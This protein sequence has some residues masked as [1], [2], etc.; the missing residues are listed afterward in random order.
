MRTKYKF[1][2]KKED[3]KQEFLL[4]EENLSP[5]IT[6]KNRIFVNTKKS[7]KKISLD[8]TLRND[9]KKE[10]E[11]H[12]K[13]K[14]VLHRANTK[15]G[16]EFKNSSIDEISNKNKYYNH[17]NK[18]NRN[19]TF[20]NSNN[21]TESTRKNLLMKMLSNERKSQNSDYNKLKDEQLINKSIYKNYRSNRLNK[22]K[23]L[24]SDVERT[25][26]LRSHS[27]RNF[28]KNANLNIDKSNIYKKIENS[29][30]NN[31][32]I[33]NNNFNNNNLQAR[34]FKR[35]YLEEYKNKYEK[36]EKEKEKK[37]E[38]E[39]EKEKEKNR[40]K[41]E[42]KKKQKEKESE[43]EKGDK[44]EKDKQKEK[45]KKREVSKI[46]FNIMSKENEK[47]LNVNGKEPKKD[48]YKR[49]Y[50]YFENHRRNNK[51]KELRNLDL[52]INNFINNT[53][54]IT[55]KSRGIE[56]NRI[57]N[58]IKTKIE[59]REKKEYKNEKENKC[60]NDNKENLDN[61]EDKEKDKE[62]NN[63]K[64][65]KESKDNM[66]NKENKENN[67]FNFLIHEAHQNQRIS[68]IFNK[69]Y[70]SCPNITQ[71][72]TNS[73]SITKYNNI[74]QNKNNF[75][76]NN[77][78]N[79]IRSQFCTN[80][81][82]INNN[83]NN[84]NENK[85]KSMKSIYSIFKTHSKKKISDGIN[86]TN[87]EPRDTKF[88][89]NINREQNLLKNIL[90]KGKNDNMDDKT[91]KINLSNI[92]YISN[93]NDVN[94]SNIRCNLSNTD[95]I[96]SY[97]FPKFKII[98]KNNK[99]KNYFK[100]NIKDIN[101][102]DN[103]IKVENKIINNNTYNTTYNI[104]KIND[105]VIK[106]SPINIDFDT[107]QKNDE[108]QLTSNLV[109]KTKKY[110]DFEIIYILEEKL[111]TI[112]NKINRYEIVDNESYDFITCYFYFEFYE[113][114][115]DLFRMNNNKSLALNLIKD[116][117]I[118]YFLS[119]EVSFSQNFNRISILLKAIIQLLHN[120]Y[121]ILIN[122]ILNN[123]FTKFKNDD[124]DLLSH[125]MNIIDKNLKIKDIYNEDNV[126]SL[127]SDNF[128]QINNY[129]SMI[130]ENLYSS[131]ANINNI[132]LSS[133]FYSFPKCL[134]LDKNKLTDI[135]KNNIIIS[136]FN[137]AYK[138]LQNFSIQDLKKFFNLYINRAKTSFNSF[139]NDNNINNINCPKPLKVNQNKN[140][141][142]KNEKI[143]SYLPP[144][145]KPYKY[146]LVLDL[147]E[148][149]IHYKTELM[150]NNDKQNKSILILRPN[151]ILFLKEMK[152]MYE[153]VLFSYA[154]YEYIDKILK[155]IE[156]KEKFFSYILDRRHITY[157]NGSYV[158][159]LSLIGRDLK[160]VIIIDDKP[161][162]F[163]MNPENGIF[164]K[165]FYGDCL[166]N[167]NILKN[168]MNILKEIRKD[169]E[170]TQDIRISIQK[171]NH[172]IFTKI[173][174]G[175]IE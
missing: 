136:F 6:S 161:Q 37:I 110:I 42:E 138:N 46:N 142:Q 41:E 29:N 90:E 33:N 66:E 140:L 107:Q 96:S 44:D 95:V 38:K 122:F 101:L 40:E 62:N 27:I 145:K 113:K 53:N 75:S 30:N 58:Q 128:R 18:I 124:N 99:L 154:T 155:I 81:N 16:I 160:N 35:K 125:I 173:T 167:K 12:N 56:V 152:Q 139:L 22:N 148:T 103:E 51:M 4:S 3:L 144:I 132:S 130:I 59:F 163:K 94:E 19:S 88:I 15:A 98:Y 133:N 104:F 126:L 158:K 76:N 93:L 97:E 82:S 10:P 120:N 112:I 172:E 166:N 39:K 84:T 14:E 2:S 114:E 31:T 63:N 169:V 32:N 28:Y 74:R 26:S 175:L 72:K 60:E 174:T 159:N 21:K 105:K 153:L 43:N 20:I 55:S 123:N 156:S 165:P 7:Y 92:K 115:I 118:C 117:I 134:N 9:K 127:I 79:E 162:A 129:Y 13:N 157:E 50:K 11:S 91:P 47:V 77:N 143:S 78:N 89:N 17:R 25:N 170:T 70:D 141:I 34:L 106:Q 1:K 57:G 8:N 86:N 64:D 168:L 68:K 150:Q 116:E 5:D 119:Y 146:T 102:N 100:K 137:D 108:F 111:K 83:M 65:N 49:F 23:S 61:K 151:L 45:E 48:P 171:Q 121:L 80:N 54:D 149:L 36:E 24:I 164:I 67:K 135:Q 73:E 71:N 147:D 87:N 109:I 85:I 52:S 69:L 131:H